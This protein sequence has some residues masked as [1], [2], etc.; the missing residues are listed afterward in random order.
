MALRR[1]AEFPY[2]RPPTRM[3]KL[4]IDER[5]CTHC[6]GYD[7]KYENWCQKHLYILHTC[8]CTGA[9]GT[10]LVHATLTAKNARTS[11]Q[12]RL[13]EGAAN[14]LLWKLLRTI[15]ES[16][17]FTLIGKQ[18][19]FCWTI[20]TLYLNRTSN[21]D[22]LVQ[23]PDWLRS[24]RTSPAFQL[25]CWL[26]V[27]LRSTQEPINMNSRRPMTQSQLRCRIDIIWSS[28]LVRVPIQSAN[29]VPSLFATDAI[30]H[31][32]L[33]WPFCCRKLK[34]SIKCPI[35]TGIC[36]SWWCIYKGIKQ[37]YD[38]GFTL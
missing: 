38:E 8:T 12:A 7:Y 5:P 2:P 24:L 28:T 6:E 31:R 19:P 4:H 29:G 34:F 23:H 1:L 18:K 37:T 30:H 14:S 36:K 17:N 16:W 33:I 10:N 21:A 26:T 15:Q 32:F 3:D 9:Q 11:V 22:M 20:M 35:E 27:S 13:C 25:L